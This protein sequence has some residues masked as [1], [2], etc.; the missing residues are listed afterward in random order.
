MPRYIYLHGFASAP[1][2]R[3]AQFF[4]QHFED[5]GIDLAV[6]ALDEGVFSSLTIGGQ[7]KVVE[8]EAAGASDVVLIG[9]SLGGYLAALYAARNPQ[10]VTRAVLLAPAFCFPRRWREEMGEDK[11]REWRERGSIDMFHHGAKA[12]LPMGYQLIAEAASYEDY[13]DLVQPSL[14]LHGTADTVVP[15]K[16]SEEFVKRHPATSHVILLTSGHELT[17]VMDILWNETARFLEL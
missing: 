15:A 14:L 9:S 8:R 17:D 12:P 7:L 1:S 11:L 4:R 16:Y 10:Q 2:S 3:K 5:K 6:P 13:P